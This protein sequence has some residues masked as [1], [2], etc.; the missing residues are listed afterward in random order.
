M[1]ITT[2]WLLVNI[3]IVPLMYI[4]Y[5]LFFSMVAMDHFKVLVLYN[6]FQKCLNK[7]NSERV[8]HCTI[9]N[10]IVNIKKKFL[11]RGGRNSLHKWP[12]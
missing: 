10:E 7:S 2:H 5:R 8:K 6:Y 3:N 4:L 9:K 1:V 11:S 12:R